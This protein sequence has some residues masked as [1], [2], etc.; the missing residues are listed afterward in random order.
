MT[1]K[2]PQPTESDTFDR[3]L[4]LALD[5]VIAEEERCQELADRYTQRA[6]Q[7]RLAQHELAR[8]QAWVESGGSLEVIDDGNS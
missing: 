7:A 5:W 6:R 3:N 4:S 8:L 2:T 1:G